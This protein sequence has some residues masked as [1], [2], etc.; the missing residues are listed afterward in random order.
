MRRKRWVCAL[1]FAA[2]ALVGAGRSDP[3][4]ERAAL[5]ARWVGAQRRAADALPT[6]ARAAAGRAL[7]RR[8]AALERPVTHVAAPPLRAIVARE[9]AVPGRYHLAIASGS[10]VGWPAR[11]LGWMWRGVV[12][13]VRALFGRVHPSRAQADALAIALILAAA[14]VVTLAALA[15]A[16]KV[17]IRSAPRRSRPDPVAVEPEDRYQRALA[18]AAAYRYG[19]AARELYLAAVARL[20]ERGFPVGSRS[21][22][23]GEQRRAIRARARELVAGFDAVVD[24]FVRATYADGNVGAREWERALAAY[25]GLAS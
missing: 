21:A 22:T 2:I 19:D 3:S 9:L 20:V 17:R 7:A 6:A 1:L 4:A 11:L 24:P 10:A 25:R 16:L 5:I 15:L 18:L 12:A 8:L 23:V 14:L 13:F